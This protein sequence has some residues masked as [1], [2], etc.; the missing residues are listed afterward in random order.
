M[1]SSPDDYFQPD[2]QAFPT[3][4]GTIPATYG[5]TASFFQSAGVR[6]ELF[7]FSIIKKPYPAIQV[8]E[9]F[10]FIPSDGSATYVLNVETNTTQVLA[11][12][13]TKD[14]AATY[15]ASIDSLVQLDSQGDVSY[16][17][18]NPS[19]TTANAAAQWS[20][21]VSLATAAPPSSVSNSSSTSSTSSGSPKAS[22]SLGSSKSSDNKANGAVAVAPRGIIG[23]IF[24]AAILGVGALLV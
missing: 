24:G 19:D 1:I 14:A 4:T 9:A 5:Q 8:Q 23:A 18:F 22:P 16:L 6:A 21:V 12:P 13:S 2:P 3:P 20:K 7:A 10:A 11:G 15:Y 17:P